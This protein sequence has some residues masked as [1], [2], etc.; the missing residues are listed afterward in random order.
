MAGHLS[1]EDI[2]MF[3]KTQNEVLPPMPTND[4]SGKVV[5]VTG[6]NTGIGFEI[7]KAIAGMGVEKLILAARSEEK[8]LKALEKIK[9]E[10]GIKNIEYRHLDLASFDS[11]KAFATKY[12]QS[13]DKLDVLV[14]NAGVNMSDWVTTKDGWETTLEVNHLSTMLLT[15]LLLPI[16][17]RSPSPRAIIVASEVHFWVR[18]PITTHPKILAA[19]N[20]PSTFGGA[21][22]SQFPRYMLSKLFNVL[23][24]Q[25]LARRQPNI[26]T[27]SVNPGLTISELGQDARDGTT[28]SGSAASAAFGVSP[29]P[30][31]EGAKAIVYCSVADKPGTSGGYYT[32]CREEEASKVTLGKEGEEFGG[33]LWKESVEVFKGLGV[34]LESWATA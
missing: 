7:A 34:E 16:L 27:C 25:E 31:V 32:N 9:A 33:R 3:K 28:H 18:T 30:T 1:A 5:I 23:F 12:I 2:E 14:N 10:T 8:T 19:S 20:D 6:S 22:N 24:A 29:R 11:V 21:P 15:L 26:F 4:M 17:S 13:G